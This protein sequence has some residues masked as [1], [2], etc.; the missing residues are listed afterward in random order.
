MFTR[1][2]ELDKIKKIEERLKRIGAEEIEEE[3]REMSM[4][5]KIDEIMKEMKI[6]E[7]K[8]KI[9]GFKFPLYIESQMKS[10]IKKKKVLVFYLS[11]NRALRVMT[12]RIEDERVSIKGKVYDVNPQT[13]FLY[14][15]VPAVVIR[16]WDSLPVCAEDYADAVK[17][18][19]LIDNQVLLLKMIKMAQ[20]EVGKTKIGGKAIT[21]I[22]ILGIIAAYFMFGGGNLF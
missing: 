2:K 11:A 12:A 20:A 15:K 1:K 13:I 22:I 9:K 4:S 6:K 14:K 19:R 10:L 7:K 3:P 16:E 17:N 21:W 8:Q 5:E 18:H